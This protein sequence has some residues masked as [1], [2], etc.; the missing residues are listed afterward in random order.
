M[1][2]ENYAA[3]TNAGIQVSRQQASNFAKQVAD[4]FNPIHDVEAKRFCVP[5]DLLFALALSKYGLSQRM[6]FTFSDM[7]GDGIALQFP[8]AA[9]KITIS[10]KN[11]KEYLHIEREG[12]VSIDQSLVQNFTRAYVAFSGHN[13]PHILIP[14]MAKH[15]VMINTARPLVMYQGMTIDLDDLDCVQPTLELSKSSLDIDRKRG[16]VLLE[17]NLMEGGKVIGRG[18]KRIILSGLRPYE[19]GSIDQL[20]E[21]YNARKQPNLK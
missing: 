11:G 13:F 4:D 5:G 14:L 9:N 10:D 17:F 7:V 8:P 18:E 2:I 20:V 6:S 3:E 15:D 12:D 21:E 1:H 16:N 19:Q